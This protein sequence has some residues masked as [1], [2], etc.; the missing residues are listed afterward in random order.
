MKALQRVDDE[1]DVREPARRH[2][3]VVPRNAGVMFER[4]A[5]FFGGRV[6]DSGKGGPPN[7]SIRR[8]TSRRVARSE[9]RF[10][11]TSLTQHSGR[12]ASRIT[13]D[14]PHAVRRPLRDPGDRDAGR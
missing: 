7:A 5:S 11:A 8:A 4:E 10:R 9:A 1:V 6:D 13:A 2:E 14:C 3:R 12:P